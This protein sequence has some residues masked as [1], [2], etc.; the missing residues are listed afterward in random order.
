M[1]RDAET[2]PVVTEKGPALRT[3]APLITALELRCRR[4]G[5]TPIDGV[6]QEAQG[7]QLV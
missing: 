1:R 5:D 3:L 6:A 2:W 7:Q 4:P